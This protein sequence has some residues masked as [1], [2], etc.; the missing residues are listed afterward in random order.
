MAN[1][2][3]VKKLDTIS[4]ENKLDL[5]EL[6]S[7]KAIH[8]GGDLSVCDMMT[9][10]WQ[11]AMKYDP[12]NPKLETR[13][14]FVLS[15]G[16]ASAVTSF[17][18]AKRGCYDKQDIFREYATDNG[19]FGMHSCNLINP[20]VDVSSGSLGHGLPVATGM[21]A[22]LKLKHSLSRVY[23]V[24]G[25]GE[26]DEG[27]MWEAAM[28]APRFKLGNLTVFV[29]RNHQSLDNFTENEMPLE[30]L[31][32]KWRAFNWRV[33]RINGN[34]IEQIIDAIDDL[35][36]VDSNQPTVIIG[37]TIKGN[38]V[39]FMERNI[40]WHAGQLSGDDAAKAKAEIQAAYNRK[41]GE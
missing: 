27:T 13:D 37:E 40:G 29:D 17:N 31:A 35:P 9:V 3:L 14:R 6:C 33:V 38:G 36:P 41:W 34:D 10:I 20:H 24:T 12:Q 5:L 16:H 2:E 22:A 19:R 1:M 28:A 11:Y 30:P 21:A 4:L 8:I 39:S 15:K 26:L 32:E 18:Q 25:D 23:V 7:Q